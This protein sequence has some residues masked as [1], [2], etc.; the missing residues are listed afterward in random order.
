METE[1]GGIPKGWLWIAG[2]PV[3]KGLISARGC[4]IVFA[5]VV[6]AVMVAMV[7]AVA[8]AVSVSVMV[9][10]TICGMIVFPGPVIGRVVPDIE[11]HH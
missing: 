5:Q 9:A 11:D 1:V 2:R 4:V 7:M 3:R 8:V 10:V 6:V